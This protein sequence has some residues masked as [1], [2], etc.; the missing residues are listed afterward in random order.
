M[1]RTAGFVSGRSTDRFTPKVTIHDRPIPWDEYMKQNANRST[2][3]SHAS[4]ARDQAEAQVKQEETEK[5]SSQ[6]RRKGW[7]KCVPGP[8]HAKFNPFQVGSKSVSQYDTDQR[9]TRIHREVERIRDRMK[10]ITELFETH[11]K[12]NRA[13]RREYEAIMG[14]MNHEIDSLPSH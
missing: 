7:R 13:I 14:R 2:T 9:M 1:E 8:C 11:V 4:Q 10:Q 3:V 12:P 6:M 5:K